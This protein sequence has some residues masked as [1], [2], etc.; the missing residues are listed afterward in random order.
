MV[1]R[2]SLQ[3]YA[4]LFGVL[5]LGSVIGGGGTYAYLRN[6]AGPGADRDGG[7]ERARLDALTRELD[8]TAEQRTRVEGILQASQ[9]ERSKRMRAMFEAC[10]EP[11]REHK[12]RV[13]AEIRAALTPAQ[14]ARFDELADEQERRFFP[15]RDA[16]SKP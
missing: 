5:V 15:K 12:R 1:K 13:D 3:I 7:R 4:L 6:Q 14:K 9:D 2:R 10:G 16:A 8:L 11:V